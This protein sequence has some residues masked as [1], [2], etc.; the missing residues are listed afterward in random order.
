M[1]AVV[2]DV[3]AALRLPLASLIPLCFLDLSVVAK[4]TKPSAWWELVIQALKIST[5]ILEETALGTSSF[6][7]P[8]PAG[9]DQK[10]S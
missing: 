5:E 6:A 4:T 2:L 7:D 1:V 8:E 9:Y 10:M 3:I